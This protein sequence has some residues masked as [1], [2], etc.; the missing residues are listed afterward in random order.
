MDYYTNRKRAFI[1]IKELIEK[2][3]PVPHIKVAVME[4]FGFGDKFVDRQIEVIEKAQTV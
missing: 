3:T 1:L 4:Q 2:R